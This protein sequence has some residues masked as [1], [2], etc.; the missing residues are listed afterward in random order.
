LE[1]VPIVDFEKLEEQVVGGDS[2][3]A[4]PTVVLVPAPKKRVR[5]LETNTREEFQA[6]TNRKRVHST[7][8]SSVTSS[9][10]SDED[11]MKREIRMARNRA[12]A[13]RTRLRRLEHIKTL[14]VR[15]KE[16]EDNNEQIAAKLMSLFGRTKEELA[17]LTKGCEV[18]L[19]ALEPPRRSKNKKTDAVEVLSKLQQEADVLPAEELARL[20]KEARMARNRASAERTRLRRL[21]AARQLEGRVTSAEKKKEKL[22]RELKQEMIRISLGE[23]ERRSLETFLNEQEQQDNDVIKGEPANSCSVHEVVRH[24]PLCKTRPARSRLYKSYYYSPNIMFL[25]TCKVFVRNGLVISAQGGLYSLK[26]FCLKS[27]IAQSD[28]VLSKSFHNFKKFKIKRRPLSSC[29]HS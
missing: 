6:S 17:N 15:A 27:V 11:E 3:L 10:S 14:D 28:V 25:V 12:S 22:I 18:H 4:P 23:K 19:P 13:E 26:M 9:S 21:E 5:T 20:R 2:L 8:G 7:C 29:I 16:L 1:Q 24:E